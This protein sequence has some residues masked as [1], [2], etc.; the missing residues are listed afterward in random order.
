MGMKHVSILAALGCAIA[1]TFPAAEVRIVG[2]IDYGET[3]APVAYA[4]PPRYRAFAFNGRPG[5]TLQITIHARRGHP[6]AFVTDSNFHSLA[7]GSA[8]FSATIPRDSK[9]ATYYVLFHEVALRPGEFTV[10][11]ERP[12]TRAATPDYAYKAANACQDAHVICPHFYVK[13]D[14]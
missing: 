12:S 7:G 9:P 8:N 11:L 13:D 2:S 14:R 3:S 5:D 6:V 4:S 10:E 1:E